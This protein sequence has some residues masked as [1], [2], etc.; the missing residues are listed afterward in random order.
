MEILLSH[1]VVIR[2]T[3]NPLSFVDVTAS[4]LNSAFRDAA[5][6]MRLFDF[7]FRLPTG[8]HEIPITLMD[9]LGRKI[10]MVA[11]VRNGTV[12]QE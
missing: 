7:S 8:V 10:L 6:T 3:T 9:D 2:G 5:D 4:I 12:V 1:D 11:Q